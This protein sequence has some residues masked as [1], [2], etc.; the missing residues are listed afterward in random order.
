MDKPAVCETVYRSD[1][2]SSSF[3]G[4]KELLSRIFESIP[5][6]FFLWDRNHICLFA[7]RRALDYLRKTRDEVVG[8]AIAKYLC[9]APDIVELVEQG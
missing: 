6:P 2:T 4:A 5:S 7:N 3:S 9:L 1:V 8:R